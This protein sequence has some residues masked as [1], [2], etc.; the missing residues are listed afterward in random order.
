[1]SRANKSGTLT[2]RVMCAAF[3]LIFTFTYLLEYQSDIL[4]VTQHVLSHGATHYERHVGAFLITLV[5]WLLQIAI[6]TGSKLNRKGHALT[7]LPSLLLLGILTD[8]SPG[9]YYGH[10]LGN[11]LWAF[12]LLMVVYAFVI[13]VVRQLEPMELPA[14]SLGVFSRMTWINLFQMIV[15]ALVTC[16]IGCSD[17]VFHYRMRVETCLTKREFTDAARVGQKSE[18]TDSSLTMLRIWTLSEEGKMGDKLFCYPLVGGSDAMLP[19][20]K[21]VKLMMAPEGRLYNELGVVFRQKLRP[22]KY[23]E[24]LHEKH[25]AKPA[26]HDW[27]LCAYLLDCNLDDFVRTLPK[28]YKLEGSLP[29]AY[30]E[31][32]VLYNH[33]RQH[34]LIIY[35]GAVMDADYDDFV[36]LYHNTKNPQ[37]RYSALKDS[38]GKTYWFYYLEHSQRTQ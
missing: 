25:F 20:G 28:Y 11:W 18:K 37:E 36:S 30:R 7:Y 22:V 29:Q 31:A 19:D 17:Q 9:I 38:Y 21:S 1:M 24:K 5:L 33:L 10:Y 4:A 35:R 8:V 6:Y 14:L 32:L 27:L 12:P 2:M 13:W 15:M 16:A 3:F 26:A 23:L 34:P